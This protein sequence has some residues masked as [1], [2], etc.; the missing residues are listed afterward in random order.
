MCLY[1]HMLIPSAQTTVLF[2]PLSVKLLLIQEESCRGCCCCLAGFLFL[3]PSLMSSSFMY[4]I[5]Y[6]RTLFLLNVDWV[7][8]YLCIS[9]Y[10]Y[11]SA[12]YNINHTGKLSNTVCCS[13]NWLWGQKMIPLVSEATMFISYV[14]LQISL[15]SVRLDHGPMERKE[16]S[17]YVY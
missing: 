14:F 17:D 16:A 12:S 13:W 9:Q 4:V 1:P 7:F 11:P 2:S 8:S 15:F 5:A 10:V 6:V 3:S